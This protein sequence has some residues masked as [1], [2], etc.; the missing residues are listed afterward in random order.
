ME[1][2]YKTAEDIDIEPIFKLNKALID[3]YENIETIDYEKV[4][5]WEK[6]KIKTHIKEYTCAMINEKKVGYYHFSH[7]DG[8][9]ELDDLYIFSQYQNMGIGTEILK[10]CISQTSLP[11]FLY[12]FIKN[13]GA[14]A[15]Y[16]RLGFKITQTI[17]NSR[18]IMQRN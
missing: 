17:Q 10:N 9:M 3:E 18:Y 2:K 13:K 1:I 16:Q 5:S 15:L 6:N 11:I 4:L 12:V 8:K 7:T 14:V